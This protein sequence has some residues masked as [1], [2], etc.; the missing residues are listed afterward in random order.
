[1]V[2]VYTLCLLYGV[3]SL[4]T[5]PPGPITA[6]DSAH[7]FSFSPIVPLGYPVFLSLVGARG[8][9]LLQPLLYSAALAFLGRETLRA[10]GHTVLA[11]AV[12]MAGMAVPHVVDFHASILSESVFLSALVV[13]LALIIRFVGSPSW[14]LMVPIAAVV[15]VTVTVRRTG[16]AWLPALLIMVLLQRHRLKGSPV[17]LFAVAGLAPFLFIVAT[18]LAVAPMVHA[19]GSSSLTGRHLFAKA[20]LVD[21]PPAPPSADPLRASLDEHLDRRYAPI[22]ELLARAPRDVRAVMTIYY[23]TCLQGP[24]VAASRALMPDRAEPAQTRALGDAGWARLAQ[25]P[26]AFAN[27]TALHVSS[28]W[29]VERLRHPRTAAALGAFIEANRPLP[30]EHDAF[31]LDPG[32][33]MA[34][35]PA[36]WVR[37]VQPAVSALGLFTAALAVAGLVAVAGGRRLPP[38][39]SVASLAALIAH[40]SLVF[41]ALLAA[42]LA[43]F[44]IGVWPAVMTAA[45]FGV[46]GIAAAWAPAPLPPTTRASAA[47]A[48]TAP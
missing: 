35:Q 13:V 22:R 45:L 10:T 43:R 2:R 32:V 9:M 6:P 26:I 47:T 34:L 24:C 11:L 20:A 44:T 15:G 12:V 3:F 18:E 21:A 36:G 4:V 31:N 30:F 23:E 48:A 5:Q 46:W 28:L 19:G 40:G 39:L 41:T 33:P 29:T 37:Y 38:L 14:R 1:M 25:A 7:Y 17:A 27:L 8:A 16:Y 42:G